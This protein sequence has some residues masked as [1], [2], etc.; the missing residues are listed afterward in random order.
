MDSFNFQSYGTNL[1]GT[2]TAALIF[3]VAWCVKNKCKHSR[4]AINSK[5]LT[6]SADDTDTIRDPNPK[7]PISLSIRRVVS[8]DEGQI[9]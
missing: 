4:C 1:A 6:C 5:C 3:G 7:P 9:V 2:V 8:R